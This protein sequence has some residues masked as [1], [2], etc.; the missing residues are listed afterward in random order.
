[1]VMLG[2]AR[3]GRGDASN[4][5]SVLDLFLDSG[6]NSRTLEAAWACGTASPLS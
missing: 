6:E 1:M 3:E 4:D 2:E 5:L